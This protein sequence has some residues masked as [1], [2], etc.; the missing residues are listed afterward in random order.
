MEHCENNLCPSSKSIEEVINLFEQNPLLGLLVPPLPF[1]GNFIFSAFNAIGQ[2]R[3]S[4]S[5]LNDSVFS[6]KL[7]SSKSEIDVLSC[8]FGGMFWARSAA[9]QNLM[10]DRLSLNI[11]P[12][13]PLKSTDGTILHAFERSY[14]LMVRYAGFYTARVIN[15]SNFSILYNNL[16]YFNFFLSPKKK[17]A[18]FAKKYYKQKS[19]K[20][21]FVKKV[22]EIYLL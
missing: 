20:L 18:I 15:I 1:F 10:T 19:F 16:I 4:I 12:E 11:F 5:Y 17:V 7:F 22:V 3:K 13:E 6:G 2:N 8:P 21:S 14:P 9:F